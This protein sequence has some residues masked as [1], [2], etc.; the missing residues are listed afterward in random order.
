MHENQL[1][2][3]LPDGAQRDMDAALTNWTSMAAADRVVFNSEFHRSA[4]FAD[5]PQM[6]RT[7]PEPRHGELVDE[8]LERSTVAPVGVELGWLDSIQAMDPGPPL[9]VWNHRWEHDKRPDVMAAAIRRLL[10][11]VDFRLAV[12]GEA[13]TGVP[14]EL[15]G[16]PGLLGERL[17]QF[18]YAERPHYERILGSADVVLS[19]ADHE[20]FGVAVVEA[21]AAG[22]LPVLP[23]RLSYPELVPAKH[24][25]DAL[26]TTREELDGLLQAGCRAGRG[27]LP[28]VVDHVRQFDWRR[29]APIYDRL[30]EEA[31]G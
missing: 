22:A 13:P 26:W 4:W 17:I 9:I 16:L 11:K 20:F 14:H 3:P 29:V 21:V 19:T 18:G 12:L 1:T 24:A 10:D 8:V 2:Y 23:N 31:V 28:A 6:L 25:A 5:L 7:M 15:E 30:L 27:S